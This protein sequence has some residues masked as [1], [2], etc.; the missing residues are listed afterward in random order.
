MTKKKKITILA[1]AVIALLVI[2]VL[3]VWPGVAR[4]ASGAAGTDSA[5]K[6]TSDPADTKPSSDGPGSA[7]A[8]VTETPGS[9]EDKDKQSAASLGTEKGSDTEKTE[10]PGSASESAQVSSGTNKTSPGSSGT[11]SSSPGST[12]TESASSGSESPAS[13]TSPAPES[14]ADAP[15][16]KPESEGGET[17][18]P[19]KEPSSDP[20]GENYSEIEEN[21]T[22]M[23]TDF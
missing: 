8:A 14:T 9:K 15:V 22:S 10:T 7:S 20:Q 1:I 18:S 13:T 21:E 5:V 17:T 12:D 6:S 11:E 19:T 2:I 3:F 16:T 23:M 4:N